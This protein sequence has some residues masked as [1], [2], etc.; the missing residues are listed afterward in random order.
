MNLANLTVVVQEASIDSKPVSSYA[1]VEVIDDIILGAK[2]TRTVSLLIISLLHK[3]NLI[4]SLC[5]LNLYV[6]EF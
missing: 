3:L 5:Q 2:E 1:E 4:R 6:P